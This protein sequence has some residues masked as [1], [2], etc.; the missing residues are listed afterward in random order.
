MTVA[1]P[2]T[3]IREPAPF[4]SA[5]VLRGEV[6]PFEGKWVERRIRPACRHGVTRPWS[7]PECEIARQAEKQA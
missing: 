4:N 2:R 1:K 3:Y 7:C 6:H 5:G